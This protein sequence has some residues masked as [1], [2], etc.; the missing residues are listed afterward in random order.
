[1][2]RGLHVQNLVVSFKTN[3]G[4]VHALRG[5]DIHI[6]QGETVALVGES[7]SGKSVTARAIMGILAK[8]ATV[9][10]GSIDFTYGADNTEVSCDMLKVKRSFIRQH[11]NGRHI[12][13]VFQ[14]PMTSLDPHNDY[15]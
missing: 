14:D 10:S 7:G 12:A 8:N 6:H 2:S 5:V 4:T 1:M 9:Q 15:W 13:M 11:I 3:A